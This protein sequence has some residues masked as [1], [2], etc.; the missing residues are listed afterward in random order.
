MK[1]KWFWTITPKGYHNFTREQ[2]KETSA[3]IAATGY[4]YKRHEK[5]E[6]AKKDAKFVFAK[7]GV[8][9]VE[10]EVMTPSFQPF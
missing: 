5:K 8:E 6:L 1:N 10:V 9:M 2:K 3:K 7:S 4:I